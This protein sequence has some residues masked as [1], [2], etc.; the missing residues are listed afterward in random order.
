MNQV[1]FGKNSVLVLLTLVLMSLFALWQWLAHQGDLNAANLVSELRNYTRAM[2]VMA[3]SA[4]VVP[5]YLLFLHLMF[6]LTVLV[7][8]TGLLFGPWLGFLYASLG[9]MVFAATSFWLGGVLGRDTLLRLGGERLRTASEA[10][11]RRGVRVVFIVSLL[12]IAPFALT[13]MLAGASHIR[14]RDYMLGSLMGLLPGVAAVTVMSGQI[15]TVVES[16]SRYEIIILATVVLILVLAF[17]SIRA[18]LRARIV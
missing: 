10:L 3:M 5:I 9:T 6:P 11:S 17:F 8:C 4:C 2:S 7:A 1:M 13:N 15:G 12:P 14:F 16:G 18:W